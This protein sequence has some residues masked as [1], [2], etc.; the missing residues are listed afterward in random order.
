MSQSND[1]RDAHSVEHGEI[2]RASNPGAAQIAVGMD[3]L[4]VDGEN[5]GRVKEVRSDDFLLARPMAHDLYV[6]FQFVL[7]VP[8]RGEKPTRPMEVLLT[9]SAAHLDRQGWQHA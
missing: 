2:L 4:G 6:P 9:V 7:S 5:V 1:E 8:D 3:V